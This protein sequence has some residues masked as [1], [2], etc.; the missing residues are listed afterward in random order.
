[1]SWI[2]SHEPVRYDRARVAQPKPLRDAV[3]ALRL[4]PLRA[5]KLGGLFNALER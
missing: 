4:P 1:M 5:R 3:N 2:P